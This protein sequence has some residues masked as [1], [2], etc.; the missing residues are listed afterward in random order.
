MSEQ[1]S[2]SERIIEEVGDWPGVEVGKNARGG[3]AFFVCRKEIGHL[4]GDHALHTGFPKVQWQALKDE[5]RIVDHPVFPGK[6]GPAARRIEDED[7]VLDAIELLRLNYDRSGRRRGFETGFSGLRASAPELLPFG[8]S[9]EA[10]AFLLE[11]EHGNIL[12]YAVP[13]P[14]QLG[15]ISRWYLN[16]RHEAGFAPEGLQAPLFV[17]ENERAGVAQRLHVRGT[18]SRRH[19]LD[20]DFEVIPIPGHTSGATAYLWENAGHRFLFTGDTLLLNRGEWRAAVLES[21]DRRAYVESLELIRGLD[22]DV[23]VPWIS[24]SEGPYLAETSPD[25]TGRRIDELLSR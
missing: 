19:V 18:F 20:E 13:D 4:H 1:R 10:R 9:L 11:R 7:D 23:L 12:V 6:P 16:H 24:T 14:G 21:S 17:H 25:E 5:G 3:L 2:A 8:P 15:E 22:F